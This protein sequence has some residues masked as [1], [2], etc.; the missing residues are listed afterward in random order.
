MITTLEQKI[1]DLSRSGEYWK[2]SSLLDQ[3]YWI[4]NQGRVLT[5]RYKNSDRIQ[6]MK[7]GMQ[8][9]KSPNA[10]SY[11]KTVLK[12]ADGKLK[13]MSIHLVVADTFLGKK[14]EGL[15]INHKDGNGLNNNVDNLEYC[16]MSYNSL[17]SFMIGT[18]KP[19]RGMLNGMHKLTEENVR[20][21]R[22]YYEKLKASGVKRTGYRKYLAEKFNVSPGTIKEIC[23]Q[24]RNNWLG[25]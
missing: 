15:V 17:H 21:I 24:R 10:T 19:K 7:P 22:D 4:S 11:L 3:R 2:Q 20:F 18:Q 23:L 25:I 6:I 16:T 5:T 13:T 1:Q 14:P 12:T 9:P 8:L